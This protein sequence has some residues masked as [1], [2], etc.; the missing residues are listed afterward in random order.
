VSN[1]GFGASCRRIDVVFPE[2]GAFDAVITLF[3]F[4]AFELGQQR[5]RSMKKP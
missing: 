4:K 5:S 2:R 3:L 1:G